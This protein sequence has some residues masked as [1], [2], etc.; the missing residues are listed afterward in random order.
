MLLKLVHAVEE[1]GLA[2]SGERQDD[3]DRLTSSASDS[4]GAGVSAREGGGMVLEEVRAM[5]VELVSVLYGEEERGRESGVVTGHGA[6]T[7]G[8]SVA[9]IM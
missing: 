5:S 8:T 6:W 2:S 3:S 1:R 7:S 4:S 9:L